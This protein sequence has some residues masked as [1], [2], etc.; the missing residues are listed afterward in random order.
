[1]SEIKINASKPYNV[2]IE[3]DFSLFKEIFYKTV[4]CDKV[5]VVTDD[6]CVKFYKHKIKDLLTE[7]TV[8]EYVI[9]AG[10]DSK[11]SQNY[12]EIL[13]FLA[14]NDFTRKDCVIAFGGGVVGDLA[15]FVASTYMRGIAFVNVATTLLSAVDSSVG[16]KT[17][18]DLPYGK[19][20]VG[21]FY[22]PSLVY[23]NLGFFKTLPQ[24]EISNGFGEIIKYY[25]LTDD[26]SEDD[27][28]TVSENLIYK[29]VNVKRQIV[30]QDEKESG[31]RKLL[32]L[33]HTVAHA[34][35]KL[36]NFT[37]PHGE[38][39]VKGLNEALIMSQ[40]YFS[41]TDLTVEKA[42]KIISCKG[43][44]LTIPFSKEEIIKNLVNDKKNNGKTIS[45]ILLNKRLKPEI[46]DL[47][48][49]KIKELY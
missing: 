46:I 34:I 42:K 16:G 28:A 5:L 47:T 4:S 6:N 31:V 18:I 11:N 32:N 20:L 9:K 22:Q 27:L 19:N 7:K 14:R 33:G 26:I 29:C 10:E 45:F 44:D 3:K 48:F 21:T 30:E 15:G 39:V 25:F 24:K 40:K 41:L 49:D 2:Y 1:M 8:Y 37:I 38:A 43:H 12:L 13:S 23:I 17:A 35:E 36:S